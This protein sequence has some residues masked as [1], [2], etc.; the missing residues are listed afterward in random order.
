MVKLWVVVRRSC[1]GD[2]GWVVIVSRRLCLGGRR[3]AVWGVASEAR[4]LG[5]VQEGWE[6]LTCMSRLSRPS[7]SQDKIRS[8]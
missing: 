2:G 8:A 7:S 6:R 1:G 5:V 4:L 3:L